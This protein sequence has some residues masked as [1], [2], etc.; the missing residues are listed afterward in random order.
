MEITTLYKRNAKGDIIRWQI[1]PLS[2]GSISVTYGIY[3]KKAHNEIIKPSLVKANEVQSRIK[4][5]RKEGY[6]S[7]E[8]LYDNSPTKIINSSDHPR[9]E[10]GTIDEQNLYSY[11]QTY[12]PKNNTTSDGFVLPMLAKTLEDNKPFDK[13][14]YMLGQ[15]KINGL[16]C[17]IG[18]EKVNN[19]LF[20]DYRF[21]YTSREGIRWNLS[22]MD[23]ILRYNITD[24]LLSVMV[25]ENVCLDGELYLP[26]YSVNDI[27]SFVKNNK[28]PQHYQLQYW[29]YDLCIENMSAE[30]RIGALYRNTSVICTLN[31]DITRKEHLNNKKQFVILPT[32][33]I[34][35]ISNARNDRNNFIN[36]GFEGLI[37]RNPNAEY[38]FGKRNGSMFK[39]KKIYDGFFTIKAIEED[40]RGLPIFTLKNDI[41]DEYFNSTINVPQNYQKMY[42]ENPNIFIG[43][44]VQVEYRERSGVKQVPFHA[45][46]VN[47][48]I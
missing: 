17:I 29:C 7:I 25:E 36:C 37:L 41:N 4:A 5:K 20:E 48:F 22:W 21:T 18:A 3:G 38:A 39:Y 47:V 26:G 44:R 15:W 13:N 30:A 9:K 28:M 2:D 43:K 12:L 24:N 14:G 32:Y 6:K 45:K 8:D 35:N 1:H 34:L 40:K 46:I 31:T 27:N 19:S 16:R 33:N 10:D 42:V 11:L 23:D